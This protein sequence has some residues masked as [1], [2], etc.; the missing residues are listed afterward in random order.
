[1]EIDNAKEQGNGT[2]IKLMDRQVFEQE[3]VQTARTVSLKP[4]SQKYS[5][6]QTMQDV[7]LQRP[8]CIIIFNVSASVIKAAKNKR[9][10]TTSKP[11]WKYIHQ[12]VTSSLHI[13]V[14]NLILGG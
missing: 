10:V 5:H 14:R 6:P 7:Y 9:V 2:V 3:L 11:L 13:P 4:L 8:F 1:M 12:T